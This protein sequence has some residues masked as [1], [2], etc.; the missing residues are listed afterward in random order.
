MVLTD[1]QRDDLHRAIAAYLRSRGGDVAAVAPAFE[2]AT[3][4]VLDSNAEAGSAALLEKKWTS[5]VRLQRKVLELEAKVKEL[6]SERRAVGD[7]STTSGPG[8]SSLRSGGSFLLKPSA[9]T[10]LTGHRAPVTSVVFHPIFNLLVSTS[11]DATTKVW[12]FETGEFERTL[13]GHTNTVQDAAFSEDGSMLATCSSDLSIKL[14]DFAK[15]ECTKTLMGHD[16][17]VSGVA[18]LKG[19]AQLVSCSRDKTIKLWDT[20]TGYCVKTLSGHEEWVRKVAVHGPS[21]LLASCS[22]DQTVMI[23]NPALSDP[24]L[25]TLRGHEN[26]VEA[27]AFSSGPADRV[28]AG[29][30]AADG[31]GSS[32]TDKEAAGRDSGK[33]KRDGGLH[34]VS[35]AR[36]RTVKVWHVA[37]GACIMSLTG[38]DNW[39]RAVAFQPSGKYLLTASEDKSIRIWDLQHQRCVRTISGAHTHFI[40]SMAVHPRLGLVA[41]GSVDQ[42]LATWLAAPMST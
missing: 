27:V 24:A 38:H 5:V 28:L 16:H 36:D 34:V 23:W 35:G 12:D 1:K 42:T 7:G 26:V 18:F 13:K 29:H 8:A 6:E 22:N 4:A 41:T 39:V 15:Y 33:A 21:G 25:L 11:E 30:S 3:G 20:S 10:R 37:S 2:E 19:S 32:T 40:A 17:N 14:W 9:Q 31:S